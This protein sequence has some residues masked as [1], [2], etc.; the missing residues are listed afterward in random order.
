MADAQPTKD[1]PQGIWQDM[2][3]AIAGRNPHILAQWADFQNHKSARTATNE[4]IAASLLTW[5]S[6][7]YQ[8]W[9]QGALGARA[10][11]LSSAIEPQAG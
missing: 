1:A 5:R 9:M 3:S 2:E 11:H 4:L 6:A 7:I 8:G 10:R